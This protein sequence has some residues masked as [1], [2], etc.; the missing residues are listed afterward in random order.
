MTG[1]IVGKCLITFRGIRGFTFT[2]SVYRTIVRRV[3]IF[4]GVYAATGSS[5]DYKKMTLKDWKEVLTPKQFYVTR[6]G[7]TEPAF[8]G[9]YFDHHEEGVYLCACCGSHLFSSATKFESG[10]GWPSFHSAEGVEG[11][12]VETRQDTSHM[13]MRTEVL[14]RE[15]KAHLG[16]VF[17][18]GPPPTGLRYCI[19]SIALNFTPKDHTK[20]NVS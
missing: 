4:P 6:E 9:K 11:D 2:S 3:A 16:H 20:N 8:R 13:M 10:S 15:C 5:K 7:G 17:P 1:G 19:N 18:D 14:C 12:S